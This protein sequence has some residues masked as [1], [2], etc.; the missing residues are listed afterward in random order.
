MFPSHFS[1]PDL[2]E[3]SS[4][5]NSSSSPP[6]MMN[7]KR[8]HSHDS[9]CAS[10]SE[11]SSKCVLEGEIAR[12][13]PK[14]KIEEDPLSHP[15]SMSTQIL[16]YLDSPDL[17]YVPPITVRVPDSYPS[18]PPTLVSDNPLVFS[19]TS[20]IYD[21]TGSSTSDNE[22]DPGDNFFNRVQSLFDVNCRKLPAAHSLTSLLQTWELS[23]RQASSQQR[24]A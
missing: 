14:F 10:D 12:L 11:E 9:S 20:S 13:D 8:K 7:K 22:S 5:S 23:V 1:F 19:L 21:V 18:Q 16:V 2:N 4:S 24:S 3:Q 17:P 15:G 6:L